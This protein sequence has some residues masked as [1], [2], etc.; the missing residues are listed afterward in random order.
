MELL[1]QAYD[2]AFEPQPFASL[3]PELS[4][5]LGAETGHINMWV[6][7]LGGELAASHGMPEHLVSA[8]SDH[9]W[10]VDVWR[11][12]LERL[13]IPVGSAFAGSAIVPFNEL[14]RSEMY[15]DALKPYGLF[16]TCAGRLYAR[17]DA[18]AAVSLLRAR[19]RP[20]YGKRD[21]A[22]LGAVMPHMSRAFDLRL[23]LDALARQRDG[24]AAFV[25]NAAAGAFLLDHAGI[26]AH[27]TAKGRDLLDD[28]DG[29]LRLARG[30]LQARDA[31][32]ERRLQR[33]L[34][35]GRSPAS[36]L[37]APAI[38]DL[39]PAHRLRIVASRY[40]GGLFAQAHKAFV[41][42]V[43]RVDRPPRDAADAAARRHGLTP[44]ETELLREL[45]AG[46]TLREAADRLGRGVNTARNQLQAVFAKT[47]THRQSQLV[48][49]VLQ[50]PH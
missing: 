2:S 35:G 18:G 32:A 44:A 49:R 13:R 33:L 34:A 27:A 5:A 42:L 43:E 6:P 21:V 14:V 26:L 30:R 45:A 24:F 20:F 38:V 7:E 25:E 1:E 31:A 29:P 12:A 48:A 50:S 41:V 15:N 22:L 17:D 19:G 46:R 28:P 11:H 23:R 40:S 9:Y 36:W 4:A 37:F 39:P 8:Y 10:R 47:G 3:L 16:D